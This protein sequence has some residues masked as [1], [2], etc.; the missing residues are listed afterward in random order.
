MD[1]SNPL[2]KKI[3]STNFQGVVDLQYSNLWY[4]TTIEV[5]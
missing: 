3:D 5:K 4:A 2:T 1:D